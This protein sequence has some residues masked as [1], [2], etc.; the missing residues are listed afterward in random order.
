MDEESSPASMQNI[1]N[2]YRCKCLGENLENNILLKWTR[3]DFV[4]NNQIFCKICDQNYSRD[5]KCVIRWHCDNCNGYYCS[6]CYKVVLKS[7][8]PENHKLI[9]RM[10][11]SHFNG[12][13][14]DICARNIDGT[15][16]DY[17]DMTC[18][19]LF[20]QDC[21]PIDFDESK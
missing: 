17:L 12:E 4:F 13:V 1:Y 18:N 7:T 2:S 9:K 8:C 19:M 3:S 21:A 11:Q 10:N 15:Q 5:P 6:D 16:D 14:C 20:C